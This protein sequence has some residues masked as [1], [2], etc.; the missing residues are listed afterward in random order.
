MNIDELSSI[1]E[2]RRAIYPPVYTGEE[3]PDEQIE[4]LL[5]NA[6]WAPT[7][8][9]TEPWRFKVLK[10]RKLKDL[11]NYLATYY[12][13]NTPPDKFSNTRHKKMLNKT[14]NCSHVIAICMQR[15]PQKRIP[16]W[17]EIASV[18]C[19]VQNMWLSCTVMKIGC[20]WSTPKAALEARDFFNLKEGER[21]LGLFYIGV[22]KPMALEAP[23]VRQPVEEKVEWLTM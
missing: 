5:Q 11:S 17:E 10:G 14:A 1:I 8:K 22:P 23:G 21:C 18:A 19:A 3:I 15:D 2:S 7:H 4:I 6:N 16:E 13:R 20:Y 12:E 9:K